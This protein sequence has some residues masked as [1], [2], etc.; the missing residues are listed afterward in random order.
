MNFLEII[1]LKEENIFKKVGR[2]KILA[3]KIFLFKE[4][5]RLNNKISHQRHLDEFKLF[6]D[7]VHKWTTKF[8]NNVVL[9]FM[10]TS[11]Y[12]TGQQ[13]TIGYYQFNKK[14]HAQEFLEKWYEYLERMLPFF[15]KRT[16]QHAGYMNVVPLRIYTVDLEITYP[17][18]HEVKY[19]KNIDTKWFNKNIKRP[20]IQTRFGCYFMDKND[21]TLFKTV[22]G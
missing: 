5:N 20:F 21:A 22:Y 10:S 7:D 11:N 6:F 2:K 17:F 15:N 8:S 16:G 12:W 14:K 18:V 9:K 4:D 1:P 13:F 19:N 3:W